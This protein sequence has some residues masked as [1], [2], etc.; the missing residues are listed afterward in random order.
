VP[1]SA[2]VVANCM[3]EVINPTPF[4]GTSFSVV[5]DNQD[6][7]NAPVRVTCTKG[8]FFRTAVDQG[9]NPDPA[10]TCASPKRRMKSASGDYFYYDL[11]K[12]APGRT[13]PSRL[14]GCDT[15]NNDYGALSPTGLSQ[16]STGP[17]VVPLANQDLPAGAYSDTVT[18]TITW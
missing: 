13:D 11:R 1:V 6:G 8:V 7:H 16:T 4:T 9:Q 2:G 10:S 3:L 15:F 12:G 17:V 14:Y 5:T 18:V